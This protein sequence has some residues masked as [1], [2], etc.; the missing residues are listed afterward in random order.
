M[1]DTECMF[2]LIAHKTDLFHVTFVLRY[3]MYTDKTTILESTFDS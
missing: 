2:F 3:S 1:K